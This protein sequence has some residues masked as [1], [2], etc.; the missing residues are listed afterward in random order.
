MLYTTVD[1]LSGTAKLSGIASLKHKQ[2]FMNN[3]PTKESLR[4][5]GFIVA[6]G[7]IG[8]TAYY[9]PGLIILC[10]K[11]I[12]SH[13]GTAAQWFFSFCRNGRREASPP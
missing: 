3:L 10:R 9:I 4:P 12:V 1:E 13:C 5:N 2:M 11:I 6:F 8:K 7:Y